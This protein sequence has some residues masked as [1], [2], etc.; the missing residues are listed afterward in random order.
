MLQRT[1]SNQTHLS[2]GDLMRELNEP[3]H[4]LCY[5]IESYRIEPVAVIGGARVFSRDQVDQIRSALKRCAYP[6]SR[7]R[8]Y[9]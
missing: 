9:A 3:R 4:R 7:R 5:A 6:S 1:M 8:A 2:I